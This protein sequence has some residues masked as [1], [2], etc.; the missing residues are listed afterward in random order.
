MDD[1]ETEQERTDKL[2]IAGNHLNF[3]DLH[4][5]NSGFHVMVSGHI[6]SG[7][8]NEYDG[9]CAK[10]DFISGTEWSIIEGN[11]TGV[12][13]HAY[14][15]QSTNRRVVWN[16]PFE[17]AFKSLNVSGWPQI[18]V[19]LTNRDYLGRDQVCGYGTV[20]VPTQPGTH[21]RYINLFKPIS[22]SLIS[23]V[24]GWFNGKNAEYVSPTELLARNE[25]REITRVQS[26]GIAKVQF[27]VT[28]K[29]M[30]QFGI[31]PFKA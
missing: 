9:I 1:K 25:G 30:D 10:F 11:R 13:Q 5:K 29:N 23:Q 2:R 17:I 26:G 28:M 14:K 21:T 16:Y 19:T 3:K 24:L 7:Q 12:S 8:I 31:F 27:H 15:S 4:D 20:H 22:S 18:V 6:E